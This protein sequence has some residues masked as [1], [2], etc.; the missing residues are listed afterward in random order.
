MVERRVSVL[1]AQRL[2]T[3]ITIATPCAQ[4][5]INCVGSRN[6]KATLGPYLADEGLEVS[7]DRSP[8]DLPV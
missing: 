5:D 1:L 4:P 6:T 2:L 7:S 8:S 3:C